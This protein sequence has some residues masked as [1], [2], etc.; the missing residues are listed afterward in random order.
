L[1]HVY[2]YYR[3]VPEDAAAARTEVAALQQALAAHCGS[4]PRLARRCDD[5]S[6]WMEIY[7]DLANASAFVAVMADRLEEAQLDTLRR[8]K[9]HVECFSES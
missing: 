8:C 9:R 2:V 4:P 3:V 7:E 1:Q 6:T 5:P